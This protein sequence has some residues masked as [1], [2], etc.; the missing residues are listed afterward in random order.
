MDDTSTI[1][2]PDVY[3]STATQSTPLCVVEILMRP[4]IGENKHIV[5]VGC[6]TGRVIQWLVDHG[7]E[8]QITGIE[9]VP[10]VAEHARKRFVGHDNVSIIEGDVLELMPETFD[11]AYC[12]NP[13]T[14]PQVKRFLD[15]LATHKHTYILIYVGEGGDVVGMDGRWNFKIFKIQIEENMTAQ[16]AIDDPGVDIE[17]FTVFPAMKR[18]ALKDM[19]PNTP[20]SVKLHKPVMFAV[21]KESI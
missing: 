17:Y 21:P 1:Y 5:D 20:V 3:G 13:F 19:P 8:G 7:Y 2:H 18:M 14:K 12:F 15:M 10:E 11:L 4:V 16:E 6:G 9:I